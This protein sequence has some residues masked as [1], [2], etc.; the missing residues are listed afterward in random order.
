VVAL[1]CGGAYSPSVL[2]IVALYC[3]RSLK[4]HAHRMFLA[5]AA[6]A[7][8]GPAKVT[9][10]TPNEKSG[11]HHGTCTINN[12]QS[13]P[14]TPEQEDLRTRTVAIQERERKEA[15]ALLFPH[16]RGYEGR[17]GRLPGKA[18]RRKFSG[19]PY[20][21]ATENGHHEVSLPAGTYRIL[22]SRLQPT[23]NKIP[24]VTIICCV[25]DDDRLGLYRHMIPYTLSRARSLP[26][27]VEEFPTGI[28]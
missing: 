17:R 12:L 22:K 6:C 13:T 28:I 14:C 19:L 11:A 1:M 26:G 8:P 4:N 16:L 25:L 9:P 15:W 21:K 3:E 24:S 20:F 18:P 5:D 2:A 27:P 23:G 7:S 10:V